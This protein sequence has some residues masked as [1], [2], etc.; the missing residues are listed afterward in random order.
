[1]PNERREIG[2]METDERMLEEMTAAIESYAGPMTRCRP[3]KARGDKPIKGKPGPDVSASWLV[4]PPDESEQRRR[5]RMARAK[6]QRIAERN[7]MI[8]KA[9]GLGRR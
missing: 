2:M 7:A 8:R 9:H 5:Q 1:M 6:R 3:G 4:P